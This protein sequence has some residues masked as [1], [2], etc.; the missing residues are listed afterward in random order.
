MNS[1]RHPSKRRSCVPCRPS[2]TLG[3]GRR[4]PQV[5]SWSQDRSYEKGLHR[6]LGTVRYAAQATSTRLSVSR[7]RKNRLKGSFL[8]RFFCFGALLAAQQPDPAKHLEQGAAYPGATN[9]IRP[10][11]S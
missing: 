9:S 7:V 3:G 5:E 4:L 11:V 10:S 8:F 1:G 6:L 2:D